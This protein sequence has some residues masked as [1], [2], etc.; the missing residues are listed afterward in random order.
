MRRLPEDLYRVLLSHSRSREPVRRILLGLNWSVAEVESLGICWSPSDPPRTLTWPGTL[1]QRPAEELATWIRSP[2]ACAA[3]VGAAVINALVNGADNACAARARPLIGPVPPHLAVFAHFQERAR[4]T[5][6]VVVGRYPGLD[7]LWATMS[8]DCL[9][10]RPMPGT[11]PASEA[12]RLLP[13]A[14]WVFIT[15]SSIA[16]QTLPGL[17]ALCR[18]AQVVLMGPSLPWLEAWADFGVSYLAGVVVKDPAA[19]YTI[20][21][22][23]GG[24]R[25][26]DD[27]VEY[28]LLSL[29]ADR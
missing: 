1:A 5:R 4:G 27:A 21:A 28:R 8:Y 7:R 16:N 22:E 24:T 26:F 23:G 14:D 17:L 11:F 13:R 12:D 29:G 9:E 6:I 15:A 10:R 19:L 18:H 3:T 2:D 20:A 25:L